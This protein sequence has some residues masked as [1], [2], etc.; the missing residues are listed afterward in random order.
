M[1]LKQKLVS[2]IA[3]SAATAAMLTLSG[4]G[5]SSDSSSGSTGGGSTASCLDTT[6]ATL[7]GDCTSDIHLTADKQWKIVGLVKIKNDST[8]T[9]DPGTT[10]YG[11]EGANYMVVTKG[12]K[13]NAAGTAANP[14]IF[15]SETALNGGTAD[16]AQWGGL[17][18]L[19]NAPTNHTDPH[20]EVDETDADFAFGGTDAADNSGVLTYVQIL[21]SGK[22]VATDLEINGLSL[23]GV[24]SGTTVDHI[25][26]TNS[27]DDCL[28]IWGGTVNVS[29]IDMTN[30]QDDF[31]DLDYGYV[32]N[33]NNIT[34]TATV[35]GSHA[36][37]EISSGGDTPMTSPTITDFTIT[38]IDGN[39]EGG[40]YI[41]D[42]TTAPKFVNGTITTVNDVTFHTKKVFT[43]A[44]ATT[45]TMSN[46][47]ANPAATADG[48][49]E[50]DILNEYNNQI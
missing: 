36:G 41:K 5:G 26:I 20:Y 29:N 43:A 14:I 48:A 18:V 28:E 45:M 13:I 38:K 42:D 8:I 34:V 6:A 1:A 40:I 35:A 3:L 37:F 47:T 7:T 2:S 21:N 23:A 39:D 30:C 46:V 31:F 10:V 24:G 16:V 33:A 32:G 50:T 22:T 15:T 12:S 44:Q 19:G 11:A 9:I 25:T 4:C 27:S 17:T 49:G